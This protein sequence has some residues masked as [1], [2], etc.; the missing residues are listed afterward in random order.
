MKKIFLHDHPDFEQIIQVVSQEKEID[1]IL[2]EKDYWIMHALYCLQERNF[3]FYLKGGTSLSKGFK[4][5]NRFSEDID[6]LIEPKNDQS[7]FTGKNHDKKIHQQSRKNYYDWLSENLN[8]TG[9]SSIERDES[10]DD[11][12]YRSGGIRLIYPSKLENNI[13]K[14]GI[15]LEI[16]FD[17]ISPNSPINISSWAYDHVSE[18]IPIINNQ[19]DKIPCYHPGYTLVEKFQTVSTKYRKQ[20]SMESFSENFM[21]HYYDIYYLLENE[22]VKSFIG[23]DEYYTHKNKR[24]RE[25]DE[26]DISK[27]EAFNFRKKTIFLEYLNQ[28]NLS[29]SLY[30]RGKPE[31]TEILERIKK[32][33]PKL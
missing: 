6:I 33:S 7:V 32:Y 12:K 2:V 22:E 23:T 27:N 25:L 18:I 28:Y 14:R 29:Q 10:F 13:I 8:L 19:A 21:R 17:Q 9:F 5:I 3:S 20:Q 15:L 4:I 31:F 11:E 26:Q 24:F 30:Y 1:P 16:G